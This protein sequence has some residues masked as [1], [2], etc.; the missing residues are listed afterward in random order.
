MTTERELIDKDGLALLERYDELITVYDGFKCEICHETQ[1][2]P[3]KGFSKYYCSHI[4]RRV[5]RILGHA[6][7]DLWERTKTDYEVS[8]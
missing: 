2:V 7:K 5:E 4:E 3:N 6:K 1:G 8:R